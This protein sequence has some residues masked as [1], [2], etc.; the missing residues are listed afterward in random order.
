MKKT[1][2]TRRAKKPVKVF[3]SGTYDILHAGHVQFFTDA[4]ALGDHLTVCF[5][6]DEVLMLGKKRVS[7]LPEDNKK[8]LIGSLRCVDEAVSSSDVHPV[9][10]FVAHIE[11]VKPDILAVTE[12][13]RHAE[14]KR[15]FCAERGI[16]LVVL[17]KRSF[18]TQTSTTNIRAKVKNN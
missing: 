15:A 5:A 12:D 14:A 13:D 8:I 10:D 9:F 6:S 16:E 1:S 3:V 11:R 18:V 17:P 7:A 4:R 2:P